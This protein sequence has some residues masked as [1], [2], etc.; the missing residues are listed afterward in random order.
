MPYDE[1]GDLLQ[2]LRDLLETGTAHVRFAGPV[3]RIM[4]VAFISYVYIGALWG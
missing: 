2:Q 1:N 3:G 4:H